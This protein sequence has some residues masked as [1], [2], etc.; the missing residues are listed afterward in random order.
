MLERAEK[1]KMQRYVE[2]WIRTELGP[3]KRKAHYFNSRMAGPEIAPT[4]DTSKVRFP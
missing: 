4:K 2:K 3:R 1:P